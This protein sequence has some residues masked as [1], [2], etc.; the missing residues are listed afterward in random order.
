MTEAVRFQDGMV[1]DYTP[2]AA[3]VNGQVVQMP[4]GRAGVVQSAIEA[5]RLGAAAVSGVYT[6]AKTASV[7]MLI[8]TEVWWDTSADAAILKPGAPSGGDFFLGT[9]TEDAASADTTC[10]VDI[11]RK[12][13]NVVDLHTSGF[14][15]VPVLTAGTPS[16]AMVGGTARAAFSATAEAQKLDLL[17]HA[18]VP[19]G[20]DWIMEAIVTVH[21]NADAD[22]ADLNIG[23]A[24][25]THASDA[26]E[27]TESVF[28]HFDMGADLNLGAES[29]DGTTEVAATDTTVD[30]AVGTAVHLAIDGRDETDIQL[31]VNGV[32]VLSGSTFTLADATG[33]L[34]VLFHLEKSANDSPGVVELNHLALRTADL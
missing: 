15:H 9:L 29:D 10:R 12:P 17:S 7:V 16:L 11:N 26:D 25:G 2:V 6:V 21:T 31:Y 24:N 1:L 32:N 3:A 34:K 20:S 22:V 28:F 30:W 33:P 27:I 8:G 13:C 23:V 14:T 5:G 4:D 19:L 18:S